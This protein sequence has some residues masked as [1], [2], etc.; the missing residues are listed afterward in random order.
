MSDYILLLKLTDRGAQQPVPGAVLNEAVW[1]IESLGGTW[2]AD[3]TFGEWDFVVRC[4]GLDDD[5]MVR[6]AYYLAQQGNLRSNTLLAKPA[7]STMAMLDTPDS[8]L[9]AEVTRRY[10][11]P[12]T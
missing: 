4:S 2:T 8:R 11:A 12:N 1:A 9:Q 3:L 7:D 6:L 5:E 10:T